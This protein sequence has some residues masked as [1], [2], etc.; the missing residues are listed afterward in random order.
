M[1]RKRILSV[2]ILT[3]LMSTALFGGDTSDNRRSRGILIGREWVDL[4]ESEHIFYLTGLL[5][6]LTFGSTV[7]SSV[8]SKK[9]SSAT[10]AQ[11]WFDETYFPSASTVREISK[12]VNIF[13]A[14][15]ANANVAVIFAVQ[16][17]KMRVDGKPQAE[18]AKVIE[19]LRKRFHDAPEK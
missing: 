17:F 12:G 5:D 7:L 13:Y 11:S 2:V 16:T 3:V 15:P 10:G 19:E 9:T 18:I 8:L 6:G 4:S 14:D 1:S